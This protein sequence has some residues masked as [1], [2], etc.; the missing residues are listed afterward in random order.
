MSFALDLETRN[1]KYCPLMLGAVLGSCVLAAAS[2]TAFEA[3]VVC[4]AAVA[5]QQ[6]ASEPP[7]DRQSLPPTNDPK[8]IVR[9]G[10]D[11]DRKDF[12]LARDY[13]YEQRV[14]LTALDKKGARKHHE[15]YTNDVTILYDEPYARRIRKDDK[16]LSEKE[17]KKE[18][19]KL[20]KFVAKHKNESQ[21]ERE[22]RLADVEKRRQESRAFARDII[23][24][25]DFQLVGEDQVDGREAVIIQA[26]PM[27]DFH[28]TQPHA[29]VLPKLRGKLWIDRND[30]GWIR[31]EVETLDTISWGLLVMRIHKGTRMTFEQTRVNDEIW[32]PRRIL[33]NASARFAL[34]MNGS[35]VWE[36][37]YSDYKKFTSGA[38]ILPGVKEVQ[39]NK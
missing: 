16:P 31:A 11:V 21:K 17:E 15:L 18:Q 3:E 19:E 9:R 23:N 14:E 4:A 22:R 33:V 8:E 7:T 30:Y 20:D 1:S 12:E 36:S 34:F 26:T 10:L 39:T 25:Y 27:K 38:R 28:P 13:T 2:F 24:A 29:D 6:P 35:F 5:Q 37:N 32:L